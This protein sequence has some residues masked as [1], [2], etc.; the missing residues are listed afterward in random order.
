ME[1]ASYLSV[2]CPNC[3]QEIK[4]AFETIG[5]QSDNT[6]K[7]RLN[8]R[9]E[10]IEQKE[11]VSP[12]LPSSKD[13][14][15]DVVEVSARVNNEFWNFTIYL[16]KKGSDGYVGTVRGFSKY[17]NTAKSK[18]FWCDEN[19]ELF[20][21]QK[22]G[23]IAGVTN[24]SKMKLPDDRMYEIG[25]RLGLKVK[26]GKEGLRLYLGEKYDPNRKLSQNLQLVEKLIKVWLSFWEPDLA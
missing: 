7:A 15:L 1:K 13:N 11:A 21:K 5:G 22:F 26:E 23:I 2:K 6:Q 20:V 17:M 24:K 16:M 14:V 12:Y 10:K 18:D 4:I 8:V 3:G 19:N 9:I 25:R